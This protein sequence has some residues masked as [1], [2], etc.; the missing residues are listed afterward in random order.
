MVMVGN[1]GMA[2]TVSTVTQITSAP[3]PAKRPS[4][5]QVVPPPRR[6]EGWGMVQP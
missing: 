6:T 5:P 1:S 2:G 3:A 4:L